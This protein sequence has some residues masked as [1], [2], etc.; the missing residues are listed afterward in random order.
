MSVLDLCDREIAAV[1]LDATVAEAIHKMLDYHVGAVAVVDSDYRVA[2]IFTERDVLRKMSLSGADPQTTPVRDLMTTPVE[3]ATRT[4]GAGEALTTM[5]ERHFRHLPVADDTGKLL[6]LLSIRNLLE[7]R[8]GDL[9][10]ELESLEQYVSN[11]GP[12]G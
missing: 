4:T 11:D 6:G 5:L 9:S 8:V 3:M 12:G 2:G 10:R 1:G 7:W